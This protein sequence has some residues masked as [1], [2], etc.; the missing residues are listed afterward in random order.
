MSIW[1]DL[2]RSNSVLLGLAESIDLT[3][4]GPVWLVLALS[5][6][7]WLDLDKTATIGLN[8]LDLN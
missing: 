7:I 8:W 1:L 6:S 3:R 5:G 4:S 2:V